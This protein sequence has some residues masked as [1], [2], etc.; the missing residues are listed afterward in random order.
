MEN[1]DLLIVDDDAEY[2]STVTRRFSRRG[3]R[4]QEAADGETAL[5]LAGRR[6]FHV[7]VL[8]LVMPGLSGLELM[9]KLKAGTPDCEIV[10][11]TGQ[12]T[13]ATAVEAMKRG[14][15]D[16]LTKPFPLAEL[17]VV[18]QKAFEQRQLRKENQQ[19]K[20]VLERSQPSAEILGRSTAIKEVL[21]LIDRAGPTD[22]AILIQ[23]ESGTGKELVA[24][25]LHR[26]SK[27]VD[28][29]LVVIN[30]AALPETLLESELFGHE[31]GSF[32]GAV[33]AKQGLFELADGGT[34]M[35]D[36]IGEMPGSLQAKLL[37][38]LED[39]SF[40][41]VGSLKECR[42]DVRLL[43]ATN[44]DMAAEVRAG[45]F[46]E[47]LYYRINVMSMELPPLRQRAGDVPLLAAKF[48]G[49]GWEIEPQA[50]QALEAY[51]WP[52]NIRQ[53]I[54]VIE[55]AKILAEGTMVRWQDLPSEV[56]SPTH[57]THAMNGQSDKL[58][59]IERAHVVDVLER[60]KGNKA[61][62]ARALGINRRSLY[63]LLEKY[64]IA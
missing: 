44:R 5:E 21:R 39:G 17:E 57:D 45:R 53:L 36:E 49:P 62:A 31:K 27:R 40:R 46:R 32:T 16:F 47:D 35:I 51:A 37:R 34:L 55:R 61:R 14:A 59:E 60:E 54:N 25:A 9:Q 22:K 63:R 33:S 42:V 28:K 7:A 12:G 15:H 38:V 13:I 24:R 64:G 52:G 56:R 4:I 30:C 1:I 3:Y 29:P 2:R 41:R 11:L 10:M 23:G 6:Q 43:A 58:D 8:D 50:M 48:L 26:A 18:V 20:A 19:L